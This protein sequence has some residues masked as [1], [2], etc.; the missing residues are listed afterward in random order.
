MYVWYA[1]NLE[2]ND[3]CIRKTRCPGPCLAP[4]RG[5]KPQP[6]PCGP[7]LFAAA[8]LLWRGEHVRWVEGGVSAEKFCG[9]LRFKSCLLPSRCHSMAA[10]AALPPFTVI[11][12]TI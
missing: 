1:C 12:T 7:S 2:E 6:E 3:A 9:R 10:S 4:P 11:E 5:I 8:H